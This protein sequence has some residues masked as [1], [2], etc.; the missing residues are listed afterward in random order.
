MLRLIVIVIVI[1]IMIE[2]RIRLSQRSPRT[3]KKAQR[4]RA[5]AR[6]IRAYPC[7]P[8]FIFLLIPNWRASARLS[9]SVI[10]DYLQGLELQ[11]I[12]YFP[13]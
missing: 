12:R 13:L 7:N 6:L 10:G 9:A 3:L 5:E 11:S 1:V 4:A 8:W 2:K